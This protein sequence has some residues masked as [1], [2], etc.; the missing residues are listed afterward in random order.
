MLFHPK[1]TSG[2]LKPLLKCPSDL[3]ISV[4]IINEKQYYYAVSE[5][6]STIINL[7]KEYMGI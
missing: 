2:R 5:V 4:G 3:T 7:V 6:H 1:M